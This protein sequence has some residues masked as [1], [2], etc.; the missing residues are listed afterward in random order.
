M[1]PHSL[2]YNPNLTRVGGGGL[3]GPCYIFIHEK[4]SHFAVHLFKTIQNP[5]NLKLWDIMLKCLHNHLDFLKKNYLI[6]GPLDIRR[7][8]S[9]NKNYNAKLGHAEFIQNNDGSIKP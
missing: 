2:S 7:Y 4:S 3:K 9:K 6:D 8:L 1:S 5:H